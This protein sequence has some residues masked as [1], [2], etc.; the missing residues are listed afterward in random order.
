MPAFRLPFGNG[1]ITSII[2]PD[3]TPSPV[4]IQRRDTYQSA[5]AAPPLPALALGTAERTSTKEAVILR[6][7]VAQAEGAARDRLETIRSLEAQLDDAKISRKQDE[8]MRMKQVEDLTAH[9]AALETQMRAALDLRERTDTE[10][11]QRITALEDNLSHQREKRHKAVE[12]AVIDTRTAA[13]AA[14]AVA[15]QRQQR[16]WKAA[17]TATDVAAQWTSVQVAADSELEQ[18]RANKDALAILLLGLDR[19]VAF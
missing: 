18:I 1:G 17:A 5:L 13:Q 10:R 4:P 16:R 12:R 8:A 14:Q 9:V 3:S 15:L 6:Q 7:K 2:L 11:T 19:H